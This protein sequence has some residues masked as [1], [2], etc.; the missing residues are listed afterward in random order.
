MSR[1]HLYQFIFLCRPLAKNQTVPPKHPHETLGAGWF[2]EDA[3]PEPL[4]PGH[5]DRIPVAFRV[6]RGEVPA[7]FD[8]F[9]RD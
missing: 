9:E 3:L 2:T 8:R 7:Y 1:H 4:D 6:W 5:V